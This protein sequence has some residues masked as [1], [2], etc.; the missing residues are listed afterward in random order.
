MYK[1]EFPFSLHLCLSACR[2]RNESL[3]EELILNPM[4]RKAPPNDDHI[5]QRKGDT[6]SADSSSVEDMSQCHGA[7]FYLIHVYFKI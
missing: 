2:P 7:V 1:L 5:S 3:S 4:D 6:D